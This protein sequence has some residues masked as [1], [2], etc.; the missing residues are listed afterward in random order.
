MKVYLDGIPVAFPQDNLLRPTLTLRRKDEDGFK[1]FNITGDLTFI[2]SDFDY[3]KQKL[4]DATNAHTS[5]ILLTFEYVCCS[6]TQYYRFRITSESVQWCANECSVT[7]AATEHHEDVERIACLKST[8]IADNWNGF[9][10]LTHPRFS[11]CN[12]IRPD[13]L[14]HSVLILGGIFFVLLIQAL[15]PVLFVLG[16]IVTVINAIISAVNVLPGVNI[17]LIDFDGD[18][19]TNIF[20]EMINWKNK[21]LDML[22]G[23]G[24]KH[25]SP[26]IRDYADNVCNKCGLSFQSSIF[27]NPGS[28]YFNA[29]YHFAPVDKGVDPNDTSTYWLPKNEPYYSGFTFFDKLKG[30][31]NGDWYING[32]T[33]IFERRDHAQSTGQWLDLTALDKDSYTC[34]YEWSKKKRNA[35]GDFHYSQDSINSVGNEAI[36]RWGDIVEWNQPNPTSSQKGDFKPTIEYAACRFRNDGIDTDILSQYS[37]INVPGFAPLGAKIT[38]YSTSIILNQHVCFLPMI[39]IWDGNDRS[40]ARV[41]PYTVLPSHPYGGTNQM[42]NCVMWFWDHGNT[43]IFGDYTNG[44]NNLYTNFW[45]IENPRVSGFIGI[46]Y[47]ADVALDCDKLLAMSLDG[48]V[49]T[50]EG[51]GRVREITLNFKDMTMNIKGEI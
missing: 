25:P 16:I 23:C 12:E 30:I 3:I 19:S 17:N 14:H 38:Q 13:W 42:Y 31:F 48:T 29:A 46:E 21:I 41:S 43:A 36:T 49:K 26:L 50:S 20:Q 2:N 33:L 32:N 47:D 37:G 8:L 40:D 11:Y 45:Y 15:T 7:V 9:Q 28:Q 44:D 51:I 18:P 39:L 1:A 24:R 22:V 35:Y 10:G 5:Y 34:C 4:W 6:T 27:T